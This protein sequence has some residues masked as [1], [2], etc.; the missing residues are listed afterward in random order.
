MKNFPGNSDREEVWARSRHRKARPRRLEAVA[1]K[2]S[3][4]LSSFPMMPYFFLV[5][6]LDALRGL[7]LACCWVC[8]DALAWP[9]KLQM[10]VL[11]LTEGLG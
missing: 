10:P 11:H 8:A 9:A 7:I 6:R 2:I 3:A 4:W 5:P 1:H